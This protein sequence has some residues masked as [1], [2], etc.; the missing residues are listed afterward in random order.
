MYLRKDCGAQWG[1]VKQS[2]SAVHFH[3]S[4]SGVWLEMM[5]YDEI[6]DHVDS[7]ITAFSLMRLHNHE[8][9]HASFADTHRRRL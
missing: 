7:V 8:L 3:A 4:A 9:S 5:D 1:L 2:R 6:N